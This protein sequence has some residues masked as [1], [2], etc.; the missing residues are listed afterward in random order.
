MAPPYRY[1]AGVLVDADLMSV[2]QRTSAGFTVDVAAA[3]RALDPDDPS[4]SAP[5]GSGA[6]V[7]WGADR[8]VNRAIGASL[9][10]L[11][12]AELDELEAFY[13]AA[14]V[15]P[16]IEVVSWATPV[17]VARLV[18][19]RFAPIRFNDLLVIDPGRASGACEAIA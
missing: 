4:K 9:D 1:G 17:F 8:F 19:R 15:L 16:S 5:L 14:G 7:S 11:G 13:D 12:D 2:L 3:F 6:M 18:A 10:D